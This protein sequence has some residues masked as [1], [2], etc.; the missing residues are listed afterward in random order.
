MAFTFTPAPNETALSLIRGRSPVAS[1]VFYNLLPELRS[2]AFTVSGLEGANVLQR[3][4]DAIAALPQ[5]IGPDGQAY[6]WETQKRE[7][8]D[9]LEAANFSEEAADRRANL[10]LRVNGFQAFSSTI[11]Q[12]AQADDDT[13]HLQYI[14]GDQAKDPTPSHEALDGIVLPKDDPFWNTHTGPWGHLGCVCYVRPMNDDLVD[15]E[16]QKDA[17]KIADG[18]PPE[19]VNVIEGKRRTALENGGFDRDGKHFD[20]S[21]PDDPG[22]FKWHPDD[23]RLPLGELKQRYDPPVW[24][25]FELWSRKNMAFEGTTVWNWLSSKPIAE[26][27]TRADRARATRMTIDMTTAPDDLAARA[28][29]EHHAKLRQDSQRFFRRGK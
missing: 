5:G 6:T 27:A 8:A 19:N 10:L 28:A 22:A 26:R 24:E 16:R 20:V 1:E 25:A 15:E 13:T 2:R 7:I 9:D 11:W 21:P 3:V 4:R 17:Q 14:H 18:A 29:Y 23:L 12:I